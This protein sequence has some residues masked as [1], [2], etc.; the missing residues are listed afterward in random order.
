M[1]EL[2]VDMMEGF[3]REYGRDE[4]WKVLSSEK[5]FQV[6][7]FVPCPLGH[8]VDPRAGTAD[9][10]KRCG[11]S[12]SIHAITYVGTM[13]G[14]WQNRMD[15]GV[16]VID[17]KTTGKDPTKNSHLILDEQATAYWTWG[18]EH[19]IN[20]KVLKPA[21]VEA[22]DGMLYTFMYKAKTD[23]R[24]TNAAGQSLNKDG[25]I[26]AKQPTPRFHRELVYREDASRELAR[27]RALE[28]ARAMWRFR[29]LPV[30]RRL[31]MKTPGSGPV[32]HCGW[33]PMRSIC[34][35]HEAGSD[36][37]S[38]KDVTMEEWDPY[39]AHEIEVEGK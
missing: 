7:M 10:C 31:V 1:K 34:E 11:G 32:N 13:D 28:E 39:A 26:S 8:G 29:Q 12:G 38:L 14:V 15:G 36:W 33:C 35:L 17:W 24:P 6:P 30:E 2:G 27:E 19:L 9:D 16:R 18:V 25:S 22:L 23:P 37:Q 20:E 5:T 3:V 21:H 4:D